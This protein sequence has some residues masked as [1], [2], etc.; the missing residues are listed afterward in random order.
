MG[1]GRRRTRAHVPSCRP[2]R[3]AASHPRAAGERLQRALPQQPRFGD[4][5]RAAGGARPGDPLSAGKRNA[6]GGLH[7][8]AHVA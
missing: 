4:P 7:P 1:G 5:A 3:P 6:G 8:S 2:L